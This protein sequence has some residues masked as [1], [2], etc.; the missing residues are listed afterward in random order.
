M[1]N[2]LSYC[3]KRRVVE[4]VRCYSCDLSTF[5]AIFDLLAKQLVSSIKVTNHRLLSNFKCFLQE[6]HSKSDEDTQTNT[7]DNVALQPEI[8]SAIGSFYLFFPLI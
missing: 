8:I 2:T 7:A 6:I 5:L 4:C 3:I 1:T